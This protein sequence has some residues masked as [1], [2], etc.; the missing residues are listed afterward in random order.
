MVK[1]NEDEVYRISQV[2]DEV[3]KKR[4]WVYKAL[5]SRYKIFRFLYSNFSKTRKT[6]LIT[7]IR[8]KQ[9]LITKKMNSLFSTFYI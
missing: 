4:G 1:K 8:Q 7:R 2:K 9:I 3:V 6:R 5:F